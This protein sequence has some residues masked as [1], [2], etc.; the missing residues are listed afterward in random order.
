MNELNKKSDEKCFRPPAVIPRQQNLNDDLYATVRDTRLLSKST[1]NILNKECTYE[2]IN[3]KGMRES[4]Y[5]DII[6]DS[7]QSTDDKV[8]AK[9]NKQARRRSSTLPKNA[10]FKV[11]S[12]YSTIKKVVPTCCSST[13]SVYSP[14]VRSFEDSLFSSKV[15]STKSSP[16]WSPVN[17]SESPLF[18]NSPLASPCRRR[19]ISSPSNFQNYNCVAVSPSRSPDQVDSPKKHQNDFLNSKYVNKD[20]EATQRHPLQVSTKNSPLKKISVKEKFV[21][22][23][24]IKRNKLQKSRR[25]RQAVADDSSQSMLSQKVEIKTDCLNNNNFGITKHVIVLSVEED[26]YF[27]NS[28]LRGLFE[29]KTK[30]FQ[31]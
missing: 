22:R 27:K 30:F 21:I 15:S 24:S 10:S 29:S 23:N 4:L 26:I 20:Y 11:D 31:T 9:I 16:R 19:I 2:V 5:E 1:D 28:L 8:Y 13:E 6:K 3:F 12:L 14:I 7:Y 17:F 25:R 18:K